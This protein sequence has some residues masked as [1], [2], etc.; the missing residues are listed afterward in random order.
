MYSPS[1]TG[2][3]PHPYIKQERVALN[4]PKYAEDE[5]TPVNDSA[6]FSFYI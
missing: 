3:L 2:D 6:Q 5:Y 1:K 4:D